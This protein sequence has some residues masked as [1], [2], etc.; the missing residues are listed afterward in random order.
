QRT[1]LSAQRRMRV[2]GP[3]QAPLEKLKGDYRFQILI[4]STNRKELH[5]VLE[6]AMEEL[7]QK[8]VKVRKPSIDIDPMNLL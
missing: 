7:S 1:R 6:S 2:L 8:G 5:E 4:K 3:A